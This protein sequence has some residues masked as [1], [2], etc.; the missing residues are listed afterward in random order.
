[1]LAYIGMDN[2]SS[3]LIGYGFTYALYRLSGIESR[4]QLDNTALIQQARAVFP[5]FNHYLSSVPE[6]LQTDIY[7]IHL[8]T[9]FEFHLQQLTQRYIALVYPNRFKR[10]LFKSFVEKKAE[11]YRDMGLSG[12]LLAHSPYPFSERVI[13]SVIDFNFSHFSHIFQGSNSSKSSNGAVSSIHKIKTF[14]EI[15]D[16]DGIDDEK[17]SYKNV[18]KAKKAKKVEKGNV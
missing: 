4:L 17:K 12:Y 16:I 2:L 7:Q 1:M 13:Y 8:A 15:N 10:F 14:K 6:A 18:K 5:Y 11:K 9:R 3:L